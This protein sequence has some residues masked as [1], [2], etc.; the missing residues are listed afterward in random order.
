[1]IETVCAA[2]CLGK[3]GDGRI[4]VL[5]VLESYRIRTGDVEA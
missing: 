5:P 1:V 3:Q 2:A 4:F